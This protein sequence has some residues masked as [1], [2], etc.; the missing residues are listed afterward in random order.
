M[1]KAL[2]YKLLS[3]IGPKGGELSVDLPAPLFF[4]C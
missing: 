2:F 1:L 4:V 3:N